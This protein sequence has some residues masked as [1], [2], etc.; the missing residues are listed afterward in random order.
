LRTTYKTYTI[1]AE[2]IKR[3]DAGWTA[4]VTIYNTSSVLVMGPLELGQAVIFATAELAEQAAVLLGRAWVD[5]P[6]TP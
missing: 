6:D 2:A 1:A 5:H 3:P 4:R